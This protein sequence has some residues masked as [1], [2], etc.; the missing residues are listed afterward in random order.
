[1][2]L[3]DILSSNGISTIGETSQDLLSKFKLNWQ[4]EKQP[5][6]LP[7]GTDSGFFGIVRTDTNKT[8]ATSK[9]G[10]QVF[11]NSELLEL[12]NE[13]A[14][15]LGLS[16]TKGGSFKEG[17]LVYL[18]LQT[19]SIN[20]I[21]ENHDKI[22]KYV[23]AM[24]SHDG[25]LSLKWGLTNITISCQNSFWSAVKEMKNSV[26]HTASMRVKIDEIMNQIQKVQKEEKTLFETFFKF[27]E[28]PVNQ[29]HIKKAVNIVLNIDLEGGKKS[30]L[31][32]YQL[33][34]LSDLSYSIKKELEQKGNTIWGLFSGVTNYTTHK[35]PGGDVNRKQSKAIGNGF[36]ID[37]AVYSEFAKLVL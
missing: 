14:N 23:S 16:I 36:K 9:E 12:V 27:A 26:R 1:M 32:P 7:N 24:N 13:A 6:I 19:G 17:G 31:T 21:G 29:N 37:N 35:M 25:S 33:N 34:R 28:V 15:N 4:V 2:N 8:F 3:T 30:D 22:N 10:Y 20:D 11:Q 5:L 18:Q